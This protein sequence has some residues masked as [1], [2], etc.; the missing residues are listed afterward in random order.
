[1]IVCQGEL[2]VTFEA[3]DPKVPV[4][5]YPVGASIHV[6][7]M[8]IEEAAKFDVAVL[9]MMHKAYFSNEEV[10][11]QSTVVDQRSSFLSSENDF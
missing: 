9:H 8:L 1:V 11:T 5:A 3:A 6:G 2:P 4:G 7:L 10:A